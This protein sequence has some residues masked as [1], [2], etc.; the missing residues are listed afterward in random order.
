MKKAKNVFEV[1]HEIRERPY[2]HVGG[3]STDRVAQLK[4]LETLLYG[5]SL[6][7]EHHGIDEPGRGFLKSF[8]G[9]LQARFGWPTALGP[10]VAIVDGLDPGEEPWERFWELIDEYE[11]HLKSSAA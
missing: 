6:A 10:I 9:Y 8:S 5:Y 11:Q 2:M 4:A 7:V 1:L 3:D